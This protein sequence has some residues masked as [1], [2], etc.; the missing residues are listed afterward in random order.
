MPNKIIGTDAICHDNTKTSILLYFPRPPPS[1]TTFSHAEC[2]AVRVAW[3]MNSHQMFYMRIRGN[4]DAE[5]ALPYP[6]VSIAALRKC[7]QKFDYAMRCFHMQNSILPFHIRTATALFRVNWNSA[8][9]NGD[10]SDIYPKTL[11]LFSAINFSVSSAMLCLRQSWFSSYSVGIYFLV[12][13]K[14]MN[15]QSRLNDAVTGNIKPVTG[16]PIE[17]ICLELQCICNIRLDCS[18]IPISW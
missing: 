6:S 11:E 18:L 8:E 12:R 9:C 17:R 5:I 14:Q 16:F 13:T 4:T 7:H 1:T 15:Q 2:S 3:F 10:T